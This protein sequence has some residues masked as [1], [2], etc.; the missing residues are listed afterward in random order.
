[1]NGYIVTVLFKFSFF[2]RRKNF[3]KSV[4]IW[5][6]SHWSS[7]ASFKVAVLWATRYATM[8]W[9]HKRL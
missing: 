9:Q 8:H 7:A 3:F 1:M 2:Q 6:S 4:K 5:Q